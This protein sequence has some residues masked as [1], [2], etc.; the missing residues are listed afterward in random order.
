M[1][2]H[3]RAMGMFQFVRLLNFY[4]YNKVYIPLSIIVKFGTEHLL[5]LLYFYRKYCFDK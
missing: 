2:K 5:I 3:K 4:I 1:R